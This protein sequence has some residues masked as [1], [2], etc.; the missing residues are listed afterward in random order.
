[1]STNTTNPNFD[2]SKVKPKAPK[3]EELINECKSIMMATINE[4]GTPLVS[5]APYSRVGNDFQI[6]VSFMAKHTKNLRDRKQVSFMFVED[7]SASKQLYARH[8]LTLDTVAE[9]VE[10]ENPLYEKAMVD[11]KERHGKV[12]E[13]L[14]D[15]EDFIMFNFKPVKGSYVNG[16]G[17]AYFVDE[18]LEVMEHRRG[19]HGAHNAHTK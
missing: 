5:T 13:V 8:R 3:V 15:L 10:K 19:M 18:N 4:D 17:S 6:L 9:L 14:G 12:V 16:F 11:L 1:M 2:Q 7:E